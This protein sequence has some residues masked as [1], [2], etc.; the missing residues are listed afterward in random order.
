MGKSKMH[1]TEEKAVE[2]FLRLYCE[3]FEDK[4]KGRAQK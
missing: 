3:I 1:K 4:E 2:K